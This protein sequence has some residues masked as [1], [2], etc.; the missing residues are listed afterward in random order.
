MK[1]LFFIYLLATNCFLSAQEYT[2]EE[3]AM[4]DLRG[5]I[6]VP[7]KK[8]RTAVLMI[9]GSGPTDRDGNSKLGY[10]NNSLKLVAQRIADQGVAVL[11]FDKRGIAGS[12]KAVSDPLA[13]RFDD[14]VNDAK[15]WLDL[16]AGR[17]YKK[18]VVIGHSQGSL[19]GMLAARDN[20]RVKGFI[21]IA[22]LADDAGVA[23]IE[24][25]GRQA[26]ILKDEAKVAL[27]S[28]RAGHTV[29]KVNPFL[30]SLFGPQI[31]GFLK[32]Y[33]QYT[34]KAE[35]TKLTIPVLIINGTTDI[36]VG[37]ENA[38]ALQQA[39]PNSKLE[40]IEGM[41]HVLKI[42]PSD[43]AANIATYNDP[44]LPLA[45]GLMEVILSFIKTL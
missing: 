38:E 31:Q 37:V 45:G 25:L 30:T 13:L 12:Q 36:Q 44:D 3:V 29:N 20:K 33:I 10:E 43:P 22:G 16:L 35:I 9:S 5:T 4:G 32:S 11:R 2:E 34:P 26:P 42:A 39:Y 40:I 7:K 18:L 17:G 1:Y 8:S 41:N 19:T 6:S 27:D 21:S 24:Q 23:I 15:N 28:L 14:F